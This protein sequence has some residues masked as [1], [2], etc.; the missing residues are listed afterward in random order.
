M[1]RDQTPHAVTRGTPVPPPKENPSRYASRVHAFRRALLWE[2]LVSAD[3]NRTYAARV[4]GLE[5]TYFQ[6]LI[7]QFDAAT[8]PSR[9]MRADTHTEQER[10][11]TS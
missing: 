4:L 8:R 1:P 11:V 6:R 3:G 9:W 5:R 7:R 10:T 2:A